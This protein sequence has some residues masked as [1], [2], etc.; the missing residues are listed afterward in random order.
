MKHCGTKYIETDNLILRKF[1]IEDAQ[2]MYRNCA[3]L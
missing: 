2:E 1:T 3:M